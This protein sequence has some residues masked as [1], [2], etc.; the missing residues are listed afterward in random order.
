MLYMEKEQLLKIISVF[1]NNS[2]TF[3]LDTY[4]NAGKSYIRGILLNHDSDKEKVKSILNSEKLKGFKIKKSKLWYLG[5]E[6]KAVLLQLKQQVE[7]GIHELEKL[8]F[9]NYS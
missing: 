8:G 7:I 5:D 1:K 9:N 3:K 4:I 2:I 6:R